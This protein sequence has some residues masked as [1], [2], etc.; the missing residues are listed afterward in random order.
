MMGLRGGW[1][2]TV[3]LTPQGEPFFGGTY[4]PP[5]DR[6]GRPGL[7][8]VLMS[9]SEAWRHGERS[10]TTLLR[11]FRRGSD[12]SIKRIW[13]AKPPASGIC[14]QSSPRL[15]TEHLTRSMAGWAAPPSFPTRAAMT[16]LL[17][18]YH[19]SGEPTLLDAVERT[20]DH[21]AAGGIYDSSAVDLPATVS[22]RVG[23]CRTS[24]KCSMTTA[25]S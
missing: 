8:R 2:L 4:F 19:R 18:V 9:L 5:D 11:S 14:R 20:L 21:I 17:R 15:G 3:F 10:C 13:T 12:S 23:L 22:T 1:P 16:S 7:V 24:R 25:S 6:Y